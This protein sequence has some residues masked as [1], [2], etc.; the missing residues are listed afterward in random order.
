MSDVARVVGVSH[1]TVRR[2]ERGETTPGPHALAS[3]ELQYQL[4][5]GKLLALVG[6]GAESADKP[7]RGDDDPAQTPLTLSRSG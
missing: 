6:P 7:R 4:G 2:W 3:L 5:R 1:P